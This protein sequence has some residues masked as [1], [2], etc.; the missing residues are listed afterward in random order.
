M[1]DIYA[2]VIPVQSFCPGTARYGT[3]SRELHMIKSLLSFKYMTTWS[4]TDSTQPSKRYETTSIFEAELGLASN[5]TMY[6][7]SLVLSLTTS[8][9]CHAGELFCLVVSVIDCPRP[10]CGA[11]CGPELLVRLRI[12]VSRPCT[13]DRGIYLRC[14][15]RCKVRNLRT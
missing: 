2:L 5:S 6:E 13:I 15:K 8:T 7:F 10:W 14:D 1:S 12:F 4:D 3:R 9:D 11:T